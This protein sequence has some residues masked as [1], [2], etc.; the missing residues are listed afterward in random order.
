MPKGRPEPL[1]DRATAPIVERVRKRHEEAGDLELEL[2]PAPEDVYGVLRYIREREA[3]LEKV[4]QR[5][6]AIRNPAKGEKERLAVAREALQQNNL[7]RIRLVRRMEQ[8]VDVEAAAALEACFRSGLRGSQIAPAMGVESRGA[9]ALRLK[10]LKLAM[11]TGWEQRTPRVE[12]REAAQDAKR[13]QQVASGF[14]RVHEAAHNLL[15][16]RERFVSTTDLELWWDYLRDDLDELDQIDQS[17]QTDGDRRETLANLRQ[18]LN[19]LH[20]LPNGESAS[21][22]E[23][24]LKLL[25]EAAAA[26]KSVG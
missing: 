3:V 20:A 2:M 16:V 10:R 17:A 9:P 1:R 12:K 19:M 5:L 24:A 18:V 23:H 6:E 14:A 22:D 15:S 8:L 26:L 13:Y 25:E 11:K 4:V 7:D 21:A